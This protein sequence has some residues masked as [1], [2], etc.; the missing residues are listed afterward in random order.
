MAP[1]VSAFAPEPGDLIFDAL[2]SVV[3]AAGARSYLLGAA[4]AFG[5][6]RVW[7]RL[8]TAGVDTVGRVT[9]VRTLRNRFM[10]AVGCVFE[11]T[12]DAAASGEFRGHSGGFALDAAMH[13][14]VGSAV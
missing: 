12:Y 4:Q 11:Y 10:L 6:Y 7:R 2:L 8:S 9:R 14:P 5:D 13:C 1:E 3:L